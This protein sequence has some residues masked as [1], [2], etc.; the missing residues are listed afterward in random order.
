[1]TKSETFKA[2]CI[3]PITINLTRKGRYV[4]TVRIPPL[5]MVR[6]KGVDVLTGTHRYVG[7]VISFKNRTATGFFLEKEFHSFFRRVTL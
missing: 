5:T 3:K 7:Y 1:M 6:A 2:I 4:E